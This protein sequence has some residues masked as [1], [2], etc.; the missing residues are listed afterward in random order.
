MTQVLRTPVCKFFIDVAKTC[1]NLSKYSRKPGIYYGT[2]IFQIDLLKAF[3]NQLKSLINLTSSQI[4]WLFDLFLFTL[5]LAE[6]TAEC[7]KK[8]VPFWY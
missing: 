5:V 1:P 3:F 6:T 8:E 4:F 2:P 7:N